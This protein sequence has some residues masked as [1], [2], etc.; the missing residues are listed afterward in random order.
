M[1]SGGWLLLLLCAFGVAFADTPIPPLTSTVTDLTQ[2]LTR[3]QV[4]SLDQTLRAFET[5]KGSQVAVL[6][7][8]T[9]E[10]E[11][12]EQYSIRVAEAWKLGRKKVGDGAIFVVAKND[13]KMRIEV[14]YGLEGALPDAIAKRI[15][16]DDVAPHFKAGEFY[17]GIVAGTDRIMRTIDGEPLPEPSLTQRARKPGSDIG[18]A[19]PVLLIVS[20]VVGGILRSIFGRFGGASLA[21]AAAGFIVWLL[22]GTAAIAVIAAIIAFLITLFTGGGNGLSSGRSGWGS[23]FG[24]GGWGGGGG[25]SSGGGWSGGGGGFGGG[26]ASGSW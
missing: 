8:P 13:R 3:D 26:G 20:L 11:T 16:R 17:L 23:G 2:T 24:S 21:S 22:V 9:V 5:R 12:I 14:G 4:A 15:I 6:I 1:R 19:L 10:P 7:V 18:S 25:S